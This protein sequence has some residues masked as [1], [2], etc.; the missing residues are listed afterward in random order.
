MNADTEHAFVATLGD[1]KTIQAMTDTLSVIDT[2]ASL[3]NLEDSFKVAQARS[4]K[5]YKSAYK[6]LG[7]LIRDKKQEL[8][9][10]FTV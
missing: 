3:Q 6:D 8:C 9:G 7:H 1:E 5:E 4:D 2:E 10:G